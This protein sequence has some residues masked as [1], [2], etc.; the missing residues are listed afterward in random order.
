MQVCGLADE[1]F[2]PQKEKLEYSTKRTC[3]KLN[4]FYIKVEPWGQI[5]CGMLRLECHMRSGLPSLLPSMSINHQELSEAPVPQQLNSRNKI[6]ANT[7]RRC[8]DNYHLFLP[9]LPL[10]FHRCVFLIQ[11]L[12]N[13]ALLIVFGLISQNVVGLELNDWIKTTANSLPQLDFM[14]PNHLY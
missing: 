12:C 2:F 7:F 14:T 9:P 4:A 1:Q 3:L 6:Y 8:T 11:Y 13:A 10:T 5:G